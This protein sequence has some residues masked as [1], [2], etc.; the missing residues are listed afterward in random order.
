MA[1]FVQLP[2]YQVPRNAL[3]DL[4]PISEAIDS[5]RANALAQQKMGIEQERLGMERERL[6]MAKAESAEQ[7]NMRK[8]Q[9]WGAQAAVIDAMP[10]GPEK[11]AFTQRMW[12]TNPD[13]AA[14]MDKSGVDRNHPQVWKFL[15]AEAGKY[16]PMGEKLKQ[17]ELAKTQ[18]QAS[19]AQAQAGN[20][21]TTDDI[22]EFKFAQSNGF[23]GGFDEWMRT[24]REGSLRYGLNPIP[25]QKPDGTIGY[26]VPNTS[27]DSKELPIPSSGAAMPKVNNVQTPTEV[28]GR[29]QFG[30][31][32]YRE[33]KDI[34]GKER[35]EEI[36]KA[37]GKATADLPRIVDNAE[38]ALKTIEDI[39]NHPGKSYGIGAAGVLPGIPGTQQRGFVNLVNQAKGQTFLEAYNTLR[40]GGQ[41]TE[42]EGTKAE[43]AIAR[44][45][46][47]QTQQDFDK[48]LGDLEDVIYR[49]VARARRATGQGAARFSP[50][51]APA[52]DGFSARKLD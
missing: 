47:A 44:L 19:L 24:K 45:D 35:D 15:Q 30:R 48:A 12:A 39:R 3:M 16:D 41:I 31:E 13:L 2:A 14:H 28:V 33:R 42:A 49:G 18:A 6:G 46:R 37:Q 8:V 51:A 29:D 20:L 52:G 9:R 5:N 25:F 43:Q 50:N 23:K 34:I 17:A 1:Q 36:G 40:G 21:G 32:V 27:G 26:M 7:A 11:Q 10:D 38:L 4:S 22:R